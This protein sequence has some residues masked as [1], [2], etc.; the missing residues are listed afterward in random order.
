LVVDNDKQAGADYHKQE[1]GHWIVDTYIA[2]PMSMYEQY[3]KN[4]TRCVFWGF[5]E[6][7]AHRHAVGVLMRWERW[8]LK[9]NWRTE[10]LGLVS[11][12]V[13]SQH[14][15]LSKSIFR[16]SSKGK[17]LEMYVPAITTNP[18][19]S[20]VLTGATSPQVE[21]IWDQ[22]YRS[23]LPYGRKGLA[24]HALSAVDLA[25]WDAIGRVRREPVY[26]MLGGQTKRSFALF[27]LAL[28][29]VTV[30]AHVVAARMPVYAT[31]PRPDIAKRL[32]FWGAKVPLPFGPADGLDG[33][34]RCVLV[35]SPACPV[36]ALV[37][38]GL[39]LGVDGVGLGTLIF[40]RRLDVR[41]VLIIRS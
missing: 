3:K 19:F 5:S 24:I 22:M 41:S 26:A 7:C 31:T 38:V 8:L 32:G 6:S 21:L 27:D 9:S 15:T 36:C 12:S 39:A 34:R 20:V 2:N 18:C 16:D 4:R 33:M 13:A 1:K 10:R 17:I 29:W 14:A 40:W 25:L 35:I 37:V 11:V 28:C 30:G 23:T